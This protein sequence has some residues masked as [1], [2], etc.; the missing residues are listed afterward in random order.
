MKKIINIDGMNCTH[1][2]EKIQN[3]LYNKIEKIYIE[4][5]SKSRS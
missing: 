4:A 5:I 1:C 2:I 3:A